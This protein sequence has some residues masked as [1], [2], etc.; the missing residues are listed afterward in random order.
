MVL[1]SAVCVSAAVAAPT[2][3]EFI[4]KGDAVCTQTKRELVP[5][6]ARAE[7]AKLLPQSRQWAATANI[8]ADQ[9]VIQKRFVARFR[10]IGVPANDAA[11]KALVGRLDQGVV[12]AQRVQRGFATHDVASLQT[13]LP[14]YL[15]FTLETNR[16]VVAYGFRS[17]GR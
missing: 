4:R 6:R 14:A 11:A 12:L 3:S 16:R 15:R 7:A 8:Y 2:R 9:I 5:I 10:A 17:C 13:A 1:V